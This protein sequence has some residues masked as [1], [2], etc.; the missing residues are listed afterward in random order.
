MGLL[1]VMTLALLV[2][3]IAQRRIRAA[4]KKHKATLPNQIGQPTQTP[5]MRWLFQ[6]M[7][8]IHVVLIT[9]GLVVETTIHG[10]NEVQQQIISHLG[11][12]VIRIYNPR[13]NKIYTYQGASM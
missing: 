9:T 2:Y 4:L 10:I 3:S 13:K 8:G 11:E 1:M 6:L 12:A 7:E 5:T